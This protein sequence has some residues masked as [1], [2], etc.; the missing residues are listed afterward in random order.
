[1][2]L[3]IFDGPEAAGKSTI[4][5]ALTKEWGDNSR[6][7]HWGPRES[8]LEYCGPLFEDIQECKYDKQLLICWSRSWASRHVYNKMLVQGQT[9]PPAVTKELENIVV[10]SGGLLILVTS[11]VATLLA[12]RLARLEEGGHKPDHPLD[13]DKELKEFQLYVRNRKWKTI[14]G[15]YDTATTVRSIISYLVQRNPECRMVMPGKENSDGDVDFAMR[16][17]REGKILVE[18]VD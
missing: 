16:M 6:V 1:M 13:P 10:Q 15:T 7:R 18:I 5:T 3:V 8:W 4:I 2:P 14:V 9:V 11:P 17:D 12:R